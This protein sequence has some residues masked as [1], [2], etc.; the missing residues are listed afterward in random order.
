MAN[1]WFGSGVN[2]GRGVYYSNPDFNPESTE[3]T[4]NHMVL[5]YDEA[6]ELTL[7]GFED[8]RRDVATDD[9]FNDAVFLC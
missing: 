4:R 2:D 7:L 6:R 9:D 3:A 8:L 5:L 1:G